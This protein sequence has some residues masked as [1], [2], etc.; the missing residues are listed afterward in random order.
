MEEQR[1]RRR[2]SQRVSGEGRD[3]LLGYEVP[4]LLD[5]HAGKLRF[6]LTYPPFVINLC[7]INIY[8]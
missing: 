8:L 1:W 2:W 3:G 5:N 7:L 6:L 4:A